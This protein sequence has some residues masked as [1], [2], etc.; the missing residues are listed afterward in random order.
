MA[1]DDLDD[2]IRPPSERSSD[3]TQE[4]GE[5]AAENAS[6]RDR[7]LR[8][9]ADAENARRRSE[10]DVTDARDYAISSFAAEL[11]GVVDNLQR[12]IA[13][14]EQEGSEIP[15]NAALLDGVRATQRQLLS[16]LAR[17]G[18][19]PID[20][21]GASFD[22]RLHEAMA[23][24]DDESASPRSVVRVLEDGYS[25]HDRLLRAARVIVAKPRMEAAARVD[26]ES[27]R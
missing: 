23:A 15:R 7:L 12:A 3:D 26:A 20:A 25:I 17:F 6:L 24:V 10:R 27:G 5:L 14:V 1:Q 18:V 9:L 4:T 21:L 13:A 2:T 19:R 8:S 22:P 11:L 16:T